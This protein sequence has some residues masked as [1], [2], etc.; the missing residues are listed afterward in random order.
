LKLVKKDIDYISQCLNKKGIG[1]SPLLEELIDH[2]VCEAEPEIEKGIPVK[3]AVDKILKSL[4]VPELNTIQ[5]VTIE[6]DNYSTKLMMK[7]ILKM[8]WRNQSKN[9]KYSFINLAGLSLGFACFMAILLYVIHELSYDRMFANSSSIYRVTM[10]S[11]VGGV[12]NNIPTSYPTLGPELQYRFDDIEKYVRIINY[13]YSRQVPTFNIEE[14]IFYEENVIFADSTF[15]GL[16]N[17][18]LL[19]GNS[20]K[21]LLQPSSVV[22][23]KSMAV[24]YFGNESAL[25]KHLIFNAKTA[26]EITGV[27]KDLPSKTHIKFDFVIP[28][29]GL[30]N[31]GMF[32]PQ[33]NVLQN[34][35]TDWFWTYMR[36]SNK[37]S[38]AKIEA[39]IN[40]LADEKILDV[41]KEN[42]AKF[43]LQPLEDIHLRSNFDYNTDLTPNGDIKNLFIFIGVGAL[44]LLISSINFINL[45]IATATRRYKEIGVSKVLGALQAQ[46][47][48]QFI[49]ESI[50][51]SLVALLIAYFLLPLFLPWFGSLLGVVLA[52]D[53]KAD[54]LLIACSI[55][56]ATV[57][58]ML[59]GAYPAF[60]VSSFEPQKVLKGI[61]KPG[62]GGSNFRRSLVTIQIAIS[63]FLII[64][65]VVIYQQLQFIQN[66]NLGYNKEQIVM[67]P[68]RGTA[69]T[70][71]FSA[72]KSKLHSSS[73]IA[74]VSSISEPI[75]RE[76]QF[77]SFNVNGETEVKF[78]KI[79]NV[80]YDFAK[81]MGLEIIQG[82]DFSKDFP[83]DS[84]SGFVINE[85]AARTFGWSD[86]IG[87]PLD[88]SFRKTNLGHVIGVVKDFN[89]EPLQKMIDPII[90]WF[91]WPR[92]YACVKI[93]PGRTK[94]A[95]QVLQRAWKEFEVE[96]PFTFSFLDQSIQHVYEKEHRLSKVFFVLCVLSIITAMMGL[97]GLVSFDVEQRLQEIGIRKVLGASLTNILNL[98]TKEYF[99][100]IILS[101][102]VAIPF[103]YFMMNSWLEVFAYRVSWSP[104]Y[105]A[106]G[107]L[108]IAIIVAMT[109]SSKVIYA[110]RSNPTKI[111]RSE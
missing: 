66:K 6:S 16:F 4:T 48:L 91:G 101:F 9:K 17:F 81:T 98:V 95:L 106:I 64:G 18:E 63:I 19:E 56:F 75:G 39:G 15:F 43:Y 97:Y 72:F 37:Q 65:T 110:A 51:I 88:L 109:I 84:T 96:K 92:W 5:N 31:S 68:I 108:L 46:L 59:S 10:S 73:A 41:R 34:W 104:F 12:T 103:T 40:K 83:T 86:P 45:S 89:F 90:I 76:V 44:I 100:L 87:K 1:Y 38:V 36:I 52:I 25:G 105:F 107:L 3:L 21:A 30:G 22:I 82:R 85:A 60:F 69:I 67:L 62:S 32:P 55:V 61:W 102:V 8:L 35:Q 79:L 2:I 27:L 47:R 13:K 23:T 7:N 29:S 99:Q 58:G 14:K 24:K 78:V 71:G 80:T 50:V 77:M 11:T 93:Q 49:L 20:K 26:L 54:W 74:D 33:F 53:I 94:E 28:M 42:D 57:I 111:L 70:K